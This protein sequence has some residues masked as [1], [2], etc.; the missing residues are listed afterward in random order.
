[1]LYITDSFNFCTEAGRIEVC[2]M[3]ELFSDKIADLIRGAT[4][5]GV[6]MNHIRHHSFDRQLR[7]LLS[8]YDTFLPAQTIEPIVVKRGDLVVVARKDKRF[9]FSLVTLS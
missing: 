7:K 8:L 1:M 3:S 5:A 4:C 9:E 6:A 2:V